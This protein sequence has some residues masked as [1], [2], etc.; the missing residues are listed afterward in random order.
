MRYECKKYHICEKDF[1]WNTVTCSC[2]NVKYLA[3]IIDNSVITCDEIIDAE[4]QSYDKETKT[5][6]TY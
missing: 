5:I 4:A 2:E 3:C 1:I 6:T